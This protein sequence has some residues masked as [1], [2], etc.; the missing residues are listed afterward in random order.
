MSKVN[1]EQICEL[2]VQIKQGRITGE[3]VQGLIEEAERIGL[4]QLFKQ[5]SF[6]ARQTASQIEVSCLRAKAQASIAK[7]LA[8]AI[9]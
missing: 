6:S 1:I 7:A 8:E 5:I 9:F 4:K 2:F 3:A